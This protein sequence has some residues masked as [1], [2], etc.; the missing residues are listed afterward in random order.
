[1]ISDTFDNLS[2]EK[3]I[4]VLNFVLKQ[5]AL[6]GENNLTKQIAS[7]HIQNQIQVIEKD[8]K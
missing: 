5:I 2:P 8:I 6:S 3:K 7:E 1:M 4:E